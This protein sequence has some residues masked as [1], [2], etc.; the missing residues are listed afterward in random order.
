MHAQRFGAI[1]GTM[2]VGNVVSM[3]RMGLE[4]GAPLFEV[5]A[6]NDDRWLSPIFLPKVPG[7]QL[8]PY[9]FFNP[10]GS[11]GGTAITSS[12]PNPDAI[13]KTFDFMITTEATIMM[14]YLPEDFGCW[15]YDDEGYVVIDPEVQVG[16]EMW[17]AVWGTVT[18]KAFW[19]WCFVASTA[20][21]HI[22][23]IEGPWPAQNVM[24]YEAEQISQ[25]Q[26]TFGLQPKY[27]NIKP[28]FGGAVE[29]YS[30]TQNDIL[31]QYQAR[32]MMA[33][34]EQSFESEYENLLAEMKTR[35]H[36]EETI[37]EFNAQYTAYSNTPAGKIEPLQFRRFLPRNV[38]GTGPAPI[39]K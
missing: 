38:Y 35:G 10:F 14:N 9:S 17:G 31:L 34:T 24:N 30:A 21:T 22:P 29:R 16:P 12:C 1:L 37:A 5:K 27:T 8:A 20:Q 19:F 28:V 33:E 15:T 3:E 4:P 11:G 39:G 23:I 25:Q 7:F 18:E 36:D 32:M 13:M 2:D 6:M 26:G